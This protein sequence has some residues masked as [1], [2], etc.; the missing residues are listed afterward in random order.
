MLAPRTG[1]RN[2]LLRHHFIVAEACA[3]RSSFLP[4]AV[5]AGNPLKDY[6]YREFDA[7]LCQRLGRAFSPP[8]PLWHQSLRMIDR[9]AGHSD[10]SRRNSLP[11]RSF[12]TADRWV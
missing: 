4:F 9:F 5:T 10:V 6:L 11:A 12:I 7:P 8:S 3:P 1:A 2:G